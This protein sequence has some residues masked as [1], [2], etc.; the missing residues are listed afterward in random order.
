MLGDRSPALVIDA[1]IAHDLEVLEIV[2]FGVLPSRSVDSGLTLSK[3][4]C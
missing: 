4:A 1:A 3:G 2:G